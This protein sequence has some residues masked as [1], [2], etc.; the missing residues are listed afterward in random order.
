MRMAPIETKASAKAPLAT[1]LAPVASSPLWNDS[2]LSAL[3]IHQLQSPLARA[4][5]PTFE[6]ILLSPS[7]DVARLRQIKDYAKA[8]RDDAASGMP[9]E[10]C[11]V[12]YYAAITAAQLRT[13]D[14][15]TSL[16][17]ESLARGQSW[18]LSLKW[19]PDALKRLFT[20]SSERQKP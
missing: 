20:D 7:P 2:D 11:H 18:A 16:D 8:L 19:L 5:D 1:L 13:A 14:I 10:I 6:E 9:A 17:G 3:L 15:L 4:G 12:L